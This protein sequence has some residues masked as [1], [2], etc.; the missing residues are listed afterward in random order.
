[1]FPSY[2][3]CCVTF[4]L[5]PCFLRQQYIFPAVFAWVYCFIRLYFPYKETLFSR[6]TNQ[7]QQRKQWHVHLVTTP[8]R[9]QLWCVDN[10][11][12]TLDVNN[13]VFP[14]NRRNISPF[15]NSKQ[16]QN[17]FLGICWVVKSVDHILGEKIVPNCNVTYVHS[18]GSAV[19]LIHL[20]WKHLHGKGRSKCFSM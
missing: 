14:R 1:M 3:A 19:L 2:Y 7:K 4:T 8:P 17:I 6:K 20:E 15:S 11:G 18:H 12:Y 5:P 9:V 16:L 13:A 10:Y